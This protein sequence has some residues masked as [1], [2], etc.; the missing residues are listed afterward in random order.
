MRTLCVGFKGRN[1]TSF[2]L[3][4]RLSGDTA[5]LTNSFPGLARDI[6]AISGQYDVVFLFGADKDLVDSVRIESCS[7][8]NGR[9]LSSRLSVVELAA[10]LRENCVQSRISNEPTHYLCNDAY[11]RLLEKFSGNAVLIHIPGI[12]Y[13]Q[14]TLM[15]SIRNSIAEFSQLCY[16]PRRRDAL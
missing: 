9:V 14:D 8:L 5:F 12:K 16:N 2:Q 7:S 15:D 3:V 10:K 1:N 6:A 11:A 13:M 4:S